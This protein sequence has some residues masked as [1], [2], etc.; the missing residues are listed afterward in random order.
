MVTEFAV[1][2]GPPTAAA[3]L[4]NLSLMQLGRLPQVAVTLPAAAMP[5]AKPKRAKAK[6]TTKATRWTAT[7]ANPKAAVSA[8]PPTESKPAAPRL[9]SPADLAAARLSGWVYDGKV[10]VAPSQG[11]A[12]LDCVMQGCIGTWPGNAI[13]ATCSST[14][15][16]VDGGSPGNTVAAQACLEPLSGQVATQMRAF[17]SRMKK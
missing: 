5:G 13:K 15:V 12:R 17:L 3:E 9:P 6:A 14:T 4:N 1:D 7:P 2:G 16:T 11:G 8:A 10:K